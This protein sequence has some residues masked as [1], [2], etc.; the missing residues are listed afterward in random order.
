M[1]RAISQ[2][3]NPNGSTTQ[4]SDLIPFG[5]FYEDRQIGAFGV[6]VSRG[7]EGPQKTVD[8]EYRS[9]ELEIVR[10]H[11]A[12]PDQ[13]AELRNS[14]DYAPSTEETFRRFKHFYQPFSKEHSDWPKPDQLT[15]LSIRP[16]HLSRQNKRRPK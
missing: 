8:F 16:P 9:T 11:Q 3:G 15:N 7:E 14:G 10:E 1:K 4:P 2:A 12:T 5:T 6:V 13:F